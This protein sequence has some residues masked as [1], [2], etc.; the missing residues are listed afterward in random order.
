MRLLNHSVKYLSIALLIIVTVWSVVFY[1]SMTREIKNTIDEEL[2][3]QK[4]LIIQNTLN[5]SPIV[6]KEEFDENL[7]TIRRADPAIA[8]TAVDTYTDSH[9][10][11]QDAD[12]TEPELEPVRI[13]TTHFRVNDAYYELQ[14][15]NTI[16][17]QNDLIKALMWNVLALYLALI[18]SI[19]Y[20]NNITLKRIWQPFYQLVSRLK[21]YRIET[22]DELSFK[23][24]KIKEFN[25]LQAA[26]YEMNEHSMRAFTQQ[27][28]F[29]ANASHELQTPLAVSANKLELLLENEELKEDAVLK[30]NETYQIIQRMIQL[31][32]SLLLLSKIENKQFA[33]IQPIDM[34]ELL[35]QHLDF[36]DEYVSFKGL[37]IKL[38]SSESFV[39]NM[40]RTHAEI[41]V[42][43]LIKNAVFHNITDGEIRITTTSN[44]LKICNT[45]NTMPLDS[46]RLFTR[47]YKEKNTGTGLGLAISKAI[48]DIYNYQLNY[49]YNEGIHCFEINFS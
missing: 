29:I 31:N 13:L 49:H 9:L 19:I 5:D 44:S 38:N 26:I 14:I 4:R 37:K 24:T 20:I 32:K 41:L 39:I 23:P 2:E 27:K 22:L 1:F 12:D 3:N 7:H 6:L 46:D 30:I 21:S 15:A 18:I 10:M 17:E 35:S 43:N 11:M 40:D 16:L 36:M 34:N 42:S 45:G 47:F 33:D 25:D 48:A 8:A 28:E